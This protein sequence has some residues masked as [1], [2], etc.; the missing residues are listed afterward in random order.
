MLQS[1]RIIIKGEVQGVF[2]RQ[3]AKEIATGYGIKGIVKNLSNGDV[4]IIATGTEDQLQRLV[5]WCRQGP[6]RAH[7]LDVITETI[8]VQQFEN[9]SIKRFKG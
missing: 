9:F 2:Y 8:P 7:V 6:P 4:E 1:L 5:A 3:S